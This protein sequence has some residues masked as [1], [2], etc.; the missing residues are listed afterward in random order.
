M[1]KRGLVEEIIVN[2]TMIL[3]KGCNI[4]GGGFSGQYFLFFIF[5][6]LFIF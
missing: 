3:T 1:R 5:E 4:N 6:K 2:K